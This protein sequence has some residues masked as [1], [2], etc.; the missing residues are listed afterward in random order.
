MKIVADQFAETF[1]AAGVKRGYGIVG[2]SPNGIPTHT[3]VRARLSCDSASGRA[4][5]KD[6][7][8]AGS[9]SCV[10]RHRRPVMRFTFATTTHLGRANF[11]H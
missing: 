7:V 3:A 6:H 2:D 8:G 10:S 4:M 5:A 11:R 1:P 9:I